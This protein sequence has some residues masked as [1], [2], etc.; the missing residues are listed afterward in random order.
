MS[1]NWKLFEKL[2][3]AI[4]HA[5]GQGDRVVW[6]DEI[7]GM[8]FDV[9][10]TFRHGLYEYLTVIE[11]KDYRRPVPAKEVRAFVTKSIDVK[12]N[13]GVMVSS[14]GYQEGCS[15]VAEDHNIE[16]FTLE[17]INQIPKEALN[18]EIIPVL[19]ICD[20]H[21]FTNDSPP[22][23]IKLPEERNMLPYIVKN[24][25]L[26]LQDRGV[27]ISALIWANMAEI[28][29]KLDANA[30]SFRIQLPKD[31]KAYLP[32]L[33]REVDVSS[34]IF[35]AKIVS[36]RVFSGDTLDP[37]LLHKAATTYEYVLDRCLVYTLHFPSPCFRNIFRPF[38][39]F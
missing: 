33:E 39:P 30:R 31:Y 8:Q 26:K 1:K 23:D 24:V 32:T 13:K 35:T 19:D 28:M 12:A 6:N 15:K 38:N 18:A 29:N 27:S 14:S 3:A 36:T 16:L 21:L 37:F 20:V 9:T 25:I 17:E 22:L 4:H 11:C 5:E 7:N 10:V 34:V 2:V